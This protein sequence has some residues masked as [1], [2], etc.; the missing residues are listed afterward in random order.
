MF[1][2]ARNPDPNSGLPYLIRVPVQ[3]T[4]VV[5]KAKDTWPRTA[6]VYC[7]RADG[8]PA[9]AEIVEEVA[10]RSCVRRGRAIDLVLARGRENRSQIVFTR[11]AGREAIFWQTARTAK[12]ARPAVRV[13]ARRASGYRT[14]RILIDTREQYPY[15][16]AKQGRVEVQRRPLP[17]GDYAVEHEGS[18]VAAVE[19]KSLADLARTLTDGSIAFLMADLAASGRGAI[20]IEDRYSALL[21]HEHVSGG[22][23]AELLARVQVRYPEIPIAFC[24]TRP[25]AE[26]W[27]YRF[28]GAALAEASGE[29]EY[30][31]VAEEPVPY[32][33]E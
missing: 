31:D 26:E 25:L 2:I 1:T 10:I 21:K 16:F 3:G 28:L 15:R 17:V 24:E 29:T 18:I 11:K 5:L 19:R 32:A 4:E 6:A 13:P 22:W 9:E 30:A 20:V 23:L 7:H 12:R 33:W 14:L 8:W 27:A